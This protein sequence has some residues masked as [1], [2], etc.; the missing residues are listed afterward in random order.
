MSR[1]SRGRNLV[2]YRADGQCSKVIRA[3]Q[4]S[5]YESAI[6]AVLVYLRIGHQPRRSSRN[7]RTRPALAQMDKLFLAV[8]AFGL[9]VLIV[10]GLLFVTTPK[11]ST[12]LQTPYPIL[13]QQH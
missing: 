2:R 11:K 10:A 1:V 7:D 6:G 5:V 12:A 13:Q 9:T 4:W 8:V 3:F